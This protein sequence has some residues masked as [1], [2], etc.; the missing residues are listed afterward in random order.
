METPSDPARPR[1]QVVDLL[2][3]GGRGAVYRAWDTVL[4][5]HVALK[6]FTQAA[7]GSSYEEA[8]QEAVHLA[9][10]QH[11]SV[12]T[13]HDCGVDEDGAF[14]VMELVSGETLEEVV[15]RGA[16]PLRDFRLLVH[17]SLE[18]LAAVHEAGLLHRDLKPG[19]LML[20]RGPTRD[21]Q[22]KLMDFGIA[23]FTAS[24]LG[25]VLPS[26]SD[27]AGTILGTVEFMAPEQFEEKPVSARS[28]LYS[29]GC[30]FYY[31][32]TAEDPFG[33]EDAEAIAASHL[34]ARVIPLQDIRRDLPD[35]VCAWVMG[36]LRRQPEDR[37]GPAAE[38]LLAF[39]ALFVGQPAP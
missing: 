1:Y 32:L 3:E 25:H 9:A 4:R 31:A 13:V 30:I 14:V 27:Q 18:G 26:P 33:G 38:A 17:R 36:L 10:V 6:R 21:L 39:E 16:F 29:M 22:V 20:R 12:V 11:P 34:D 8:W 2:G 7:D 5:R 15:G 24:F 23:G 19:N 35:A 28:E 37:P